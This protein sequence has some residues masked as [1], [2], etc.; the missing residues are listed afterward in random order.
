M[1]TSTMFTKTGYRTAVA[2][3]IFVVGLVVLVVVGAVA[4]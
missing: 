4:G 1:S 2:V 3:V